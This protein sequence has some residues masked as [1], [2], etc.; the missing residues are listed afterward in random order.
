MLLLGPSSERSTRPYRP[1]RG[2]VERR[3]AAAK[4]VIALTGSVDVLRIAATRTLDY[5]QSHSELATQ[6]GIRCTGLRSEIRERL[7]NGSD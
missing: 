1:W 6:T 3:T 7:I 4:A 2:R 5:P